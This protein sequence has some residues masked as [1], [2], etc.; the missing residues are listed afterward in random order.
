[1]KYKKL[2][3]AFVEAIRKAFFQENIRNFF[4]VSISGNPEFFLIL[5]LESSI[6]PEYKKFSQS[7]FFFFFELGLKSAPG[8]CILY[9][10]RPLNNGPKSKLVRPNEKHTGNSVRRQKLEAKLS[11]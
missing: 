6:F 5:E 11:A 1:M 4:R 8:S 10:S 3:E 2:F 9:Y 7:G